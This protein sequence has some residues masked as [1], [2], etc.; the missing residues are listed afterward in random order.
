MTICPVIKIEI[1]KD[2]VIT[3]P[4]PPGRG[5]SLKALQISIKGSISIAIS[6]A[7]TRA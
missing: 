5:F 4:P 3:D 2:S 6:T 1:V 7:L